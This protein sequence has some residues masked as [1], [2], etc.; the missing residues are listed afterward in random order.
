MSTFVSTTSV[1]GNEKVTHRLLTAEQERELCRRIQF[2]DQSARNQLAAANIRLVLSLANGY[3]T[4][5]SDVTDLVQE[6][7]IGLLRAAEKFDAS[8]GYRF[9]T[10][11]TYWIKQAI[12]MALARDLYPVSFPRHVYDYAIKVR[13]ALKTLSPHRED[14]VE[15]LSGLTGA[16]AEV[17]AALLR[18]L[19]PIYSLDAPLMDGED[20]T[21]GSFIAAPAEVP[22]PENAELHALLARY[23]AILSDTDRIVIEM[24]YGV[25]QYKGHSSTVA[26]VAAARGCSR[27]RVYQREQHAFKQMRSAMS[28]FGR[29]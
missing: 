3:A 28:E 13:R 8:S 20:A 7:C 15:Q 27:Q 29:L 6:G 21:L 16:S 23:L 14:D 10:Y 18:W 17:M 19:K 4:Y 12:T 26:E 25:G 24:H 2:G 1:P 22:V 11:A 9:S 5:V